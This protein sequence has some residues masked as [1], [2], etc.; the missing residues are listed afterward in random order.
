MSLRGEGEALS[1]ASA[2]ASAARAAG[3]AAEQAPFVPEW[4]DEL[5]SVVRG[6]GISPVA[7]YVEKGM[8]KSPP[9]PLL[10]R[11]RWL[12]TVTQEYLGHR[13][14]LRGRA[15][16]VTE[17]GIPVVQ[18]L[19]FDATGNFWEENSRPLERPKPGRNRALIVDKGLR[20]GPARSVGGS[21]KRPLTRYFVESD[22]IRTLCAVATHR[23][24]T[25]EA[26]QPE[27][28]VVDV[29]FFGR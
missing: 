21:H 17:Y 26:D 29:G 5:L 3:E 27:P 16:D 14:F 23:L 19:A 6:A 24:T 18:E 22:R 12:Y 7:C 15:G 4:F 28:G 20:P 1:Q 13:W 11:K 2:R 25:G 8:Q 10:L 9:Q